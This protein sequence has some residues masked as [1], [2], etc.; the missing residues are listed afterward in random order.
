MRTSHALL[1]RLRHDAKFDFRK[2]SVEYVD[3]GAP[4]DRS[5]VLGD[6]I[7]GLERGGMQIKSIKGE[8]Y[9]PFHRMRRISYD[10]QIMW[11]KSG[12]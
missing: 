2:V 9:I 3:R 8:T 6:Q 5:A 11:E 1:L 4:G 10:G 12:T 7:L